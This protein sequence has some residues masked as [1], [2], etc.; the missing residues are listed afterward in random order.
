MTCIV[1]SVGDVIYAIIHLKSNQFSVFKNWK[2]V[3]TLIERLFFK[4]MSFLTTTAV[5]S[6]ASKVS[7]VDDLKFKNSIFWVEIHYFLNQFFKIHF[8][9]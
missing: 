1:G 2:R 5:S 4:Q 7:R 6:N 8:Q 9:K 3:E